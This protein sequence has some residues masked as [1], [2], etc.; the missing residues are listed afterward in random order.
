MFVAALA[1]FLHAF[2]VY[3]HHVIETTL[4]NSALSPCYDA[5]KNELALRFSYEFNQAQPRQTGPATNYIYC[6]W[7]LFCLR[8]PCRAVNQSAFP[9]F[10]F[11][12]PEQSLI[13]EWHLSLVITID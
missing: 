13:I 3:W 9:I 10:S 5:I 2:C 8:S 12:L 1:T 11:D 6:S 4:I 7:A